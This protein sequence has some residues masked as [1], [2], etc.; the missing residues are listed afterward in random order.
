MGQREKLKFGYA[1]NAIVRKGFLCDSVGMG[2]LG[3]IS[4]KNKIKGM[5]LTSNRFST[6]RNNQAPHV[7]NYRHRDEREAY[8]KP[9]AEETVLLVNHKRKYD[10]ID[11]LQGQRKVHCKSRNFFERPDVK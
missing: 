6:G 8:I 2:S 11:G 7:E 1:E 3:L 9:V 10:S 5:R 4:R